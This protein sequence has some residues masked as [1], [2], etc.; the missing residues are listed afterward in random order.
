M[1]WSRNRVRHWQSSKSPLYS[2]NRASASTV[3]PLSACSSAS[4]SLSLRLWSILHTS[5]PDLRLRELQNN[6]ADRYRKDSLQLLRI[7]ND[8]N[9]LGLAMRDMLA[10]DE[11]YPLTAWSAQFQQV[12]DRSQR[13]SSARRQFASVRRTPEQIGNFRIRS[14]S[15]G[16]RSITR[17]LWLHDGQRKK[18]PRTNSRFAAGPPSIAIAAVARQLVENNEGEKKQAALQ[19]GEIYDRVQR[20]VYW[21]LAAI[22]AAILLTSLYLIRSNRLPVC[23]DSLR[24]QIS[25]ASLPKN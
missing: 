11:P 2:P 23:P 6:L 17:F 12:H 24:F 5:P 8:L 15:S 16:M 1:T 4:S 14:P 21:F 19:I 9:S 22:L 13:C 20:R 10:N 3:L 25:A 18:R 7:Q